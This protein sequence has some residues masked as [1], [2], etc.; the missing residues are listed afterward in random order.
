M[1]TV[2]PIVTAARASSYNVVIHFP[3]NF[4]EGNMIK[5]PTSEDSGLLECD[6]LLM[7]MWF[8]TF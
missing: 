1:K 7:G 8:M 2:I 5:E 3:A 6:A 4:T